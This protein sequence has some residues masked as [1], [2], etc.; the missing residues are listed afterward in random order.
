MRIANRITYDGQDLRLGPEN[1]RNVFPLLNF[2]WSLLITFLTRV[3]GVFPFLISQVLLD[4]TDISN[5]LG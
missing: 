5:A 2:P 1:S 3:L 4:S